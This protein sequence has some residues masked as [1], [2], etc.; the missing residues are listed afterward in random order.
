MNKTNH[1][2]STITSHVYCVCVF[3][4]YLGISTYIHKYAIQYYFSKLLLP[5]SLLC[6]DTIEINDN[7]VYGIYG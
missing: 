1:N 2:A 4:W 5:S 6:V 3:I 7:N